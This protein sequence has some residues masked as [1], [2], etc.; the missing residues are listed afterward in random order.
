MATF[1]EFYNSLPEDSNKRGEHFEKVFVPWFLKTDP[2]W[3]TKVSQVWLWDD[4]PQRW[5]KDCGIDLVY[6][7]QQGKHWAVQSKC[8]SPDREISKAEID[9]FL[10]ESSDSRIHGRLLIA[11]TDG[12]GKNAQQ[13]IDRQEKQVVCFLLEHFRHSAVEFPSAPEDL[14]TGQRKKK[15]TPREHQQEAIT[16]VVEGFQKENRGKLLM[17]CGTGKTLTSLW[18]K[19]ALN[20]KRTLVLVPSLGLLSQTLREW[21]ATSQQQFNWI[22]VCSDKS[23]AKQDKTTDNM[24]ESVSALGVPVTSDPVDI[25][26]FLLDND[27]GIVFS[28][29]QSSPLVTE[30]QRES[31]VPAFDIA[32][33]DE[34][35]RCTGKISS[36]FG[37]ILDDQKIRSKK[38]LFMTATPR[39]LSRQIKKKADEENINLACMD[40]VSQFGEVFHQLNFSKAIEKELLSDYQVVIV[41]V[42]DPSV[43][44]QII[45]RM[46]VD[47]GN[48]C[49]IDTET[50]ANHIALAKAIKDYD[51]SRMITFHSRV[52]SAKK[53][54]EDHPLILDWIPDESKSRKSAMTSYVSGEMN[55]KIR[56]T[57]IN[58]LRN[59]SE[60]EVGILAN[61]RCLSEGVDVPTLDGI[62]FFDPRS[63]QVDII[64][65]VGRAIRKSENKT[66]GYIILPVYLGDTTNVEDEI[67]QSRFKDIWSIILALKSQ[68]DS[69]RDE[70][71]Q[72]RVEL[73]RRN[74][75]TE[76]VKGFSKI[77]FDLPSNISTSFADS[78]RTILVRE[79]TDNWMEI[80]GQ[81]KQ[82]VEKNGNSYIPSNHPDLGRWADTQRQNMAKGKLSKI[83]IK[84]LDTIR[85]TWNLLEHKWQ[86]KYQQL[87]QYKHENG[88]LEIASD[89]PLLGN[90]TRTIRQQKVTGKLPEEHIKLLDAV[91]F[92]WDP[93]ENKWQEKYQQLK[94]YIQDNGHSL[95][96]KRDP[97]LGIWVL[98][99]RQQNTL[100]K[101]SEEHI[102]LLNAVGFIWDPLEHKWQEK[103][104]QLKQYIQDNGH[105]LVP[106]RDPILGLWVYTQRQQNNRNKLSKERIQLLDEIRFI[107]DPLEHEWQENYNK[108]KQCIHDSSSFLKTDLKLR[109]WTYAQRQKKIKGKLS[110]EHIKRLDAIGFI[111]DPMEQEWQENYKKLKQYFQENG[112]AKVPIKHPEIGMWVT[113]QRQTKS[114]GK[115]SEERIR[116]LDELGFIWDPS[117]N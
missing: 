64:Q 16:N 68:D 1:D 72:L 47:T 34:A 89:H 42:D 96:P 39:V 85:F 90:W 50:L 21:T 5:G 25:K 46:L 62:A 102:K 40:D 23:V 83:R 33:A 82:Y 94:Q 59:I 7:D 26:R 112:H 75:P 12:I 51:L 20:A 100:G 116:L 71:D 87:K 69:M 19:E 41:G 92:I 93:L 58:K 24:I 43:Q 103:Y 110:K 107:W 18:I 81:L 66:D 115:L 76:S 111:W 73:G 114:N 31:E 104:Q 79:T 44:A 91:G 57:E 48:E 54:S 9:S 36:A 61:A 86:E 88:N 45:D 37:S 30:S 13:V 106:K 67:L 49:N 4:Y 108:L 53:F 77:V 105:S 78:L 95:V 29:Y 63:S 117:N 98:V 99:Q 113:T 60:Q 15:H 97:I 22:C 52:K 6:E 109:N 32:F 27:G 74:A 28:T 56:N 65:A 10:S 14:T 11:S 8:V 70:L 55:A 35:H 38:R 101:L 84:L 17:A 2:V 3:S 80:Y